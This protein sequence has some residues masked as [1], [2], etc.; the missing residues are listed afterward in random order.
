MNALRILPALIVL[1]LTA[2]SSQQLYTTGQQYQRNQCQ[3][4]PNQVDRER[5]LDKA[6]STYNDYR[7]EPR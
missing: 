1:L 3:Q 2:C 7:R 5:C 6:G 4:L